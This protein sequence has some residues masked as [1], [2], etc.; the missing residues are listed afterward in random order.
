MSECPFCKTQLKVGASVCTGCGARACKGY[1][2]K[3][4]IASVFIVGMIVS[5]IAAFFLALYTPLSYLNTFI[6]LCIVFCLGIPAIILYKNK[7]NIVFV[8]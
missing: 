8:R 5:F 6:F 4:K 1:V 2:S 7:D 3:E